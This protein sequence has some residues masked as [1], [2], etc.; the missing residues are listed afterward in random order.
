M[1]RWLPCEELDDLHALDQLVAELDTLVARRHR[2]HRVLLRALG[3]PRVEGHR[4]DHHTNGSKPRGTHERIEHVRRDHQLHGP[5]PQQMHVW[6]SVG[7]LLR[8][9][10][11]VRD[12]GARPEVVALVVREVE[13]LGIH[14]LPHRRAGP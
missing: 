14:H 5:L 12:D 10:L 11:H 9:D 2:A 3:Q 6:Q 7:H 13:R 1:K 4:D 8:V